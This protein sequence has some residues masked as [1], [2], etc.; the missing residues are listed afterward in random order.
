MA[1]IATRRVNCVCRGAARLVEI[2]AAS[3]RVTTPQTLTDPDGIRLAL[4]PR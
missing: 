1:I 2:S 4:V 3:S